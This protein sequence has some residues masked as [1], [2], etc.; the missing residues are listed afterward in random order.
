MLSTQLTVPIDFHTIYYIIIYFPC[1]NSMGTVNC[2]PT[3][4]NQN[5]FSCVQQNN[6]THSGTKQHEDE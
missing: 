1:K 4:I 6:E 2:V 5:I 3:I